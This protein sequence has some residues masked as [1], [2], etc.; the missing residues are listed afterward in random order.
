M[1]APA[2]RLEVGVADQN[3]QSI[4]KA[5]RMDVYSKG[6]TT[7]GGARRNASVIQNW[8]SAPAMPTPPSQSQS[9]DCTEF[10]PLIESNPEPTPTSARFQNT[11]D[12][13]EFCLPSERTVS[14][15]SE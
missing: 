8:P 15:L 2:S 4:P 3:T 10:Q 1:A 14:A 12:M 9:L 11:I 6:A 5:Q 13:L 7:E